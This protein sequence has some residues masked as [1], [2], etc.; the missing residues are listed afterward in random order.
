MTSF[1]KAARNFCLCALTAPA[2]STPASLDVVSGDYPRAFFFRFSEGAA[3]QKGNS[4]EKWEV[5]FSKLMGSRARLSRKKFPGAPSATSISSPAS[6]NSIRA[7]L[8][9]KPTTPA[10]DHARVRLRDGPRSPRRRL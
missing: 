6:S 8:Q 2:A 7:S 10:R 9:P 3:A 1:S 5:A 4:F